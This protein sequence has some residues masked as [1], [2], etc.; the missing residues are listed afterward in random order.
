MK[1]KYHLLATDESLTKESVHVLIFLSNSFRKKEKEGERTKKRG[2]FLR[3]CEKKMRGKRE[4]WDKRLRV[5]ECVTARR[6]RP[7]HWALWG[8]RRSEA[9]IEGKAWGAQRGS[10]FCVFFFFRISWV[11]FQISRKTFRLV[12]LLV[13]DNS[14]IFTIFSIWPQPFILMIK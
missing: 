11:L 6:T 13:S 9:A 7:V 8:E 5:T 3:P 14:S 12:A 1:K 2:P 4:L 10:R